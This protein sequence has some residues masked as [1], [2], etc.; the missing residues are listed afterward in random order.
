MFRGTSKLLID[1][2]GRIS[3]PTRYREGL[4]VQSDSKVVVTVDRDRCLLVY[5]L[6]NWEPIEKKLSILPALD[7]EVRH[8][9]RLIL[10]YASEVDIDK[11]G[12]VLIS[13]ELREFAGLK[14]QAILTGQG[15]KFELWDEGSWTE[16]M[17]AW[18]NTSQKKE[19]P[20]EL[21][22]LSL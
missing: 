4:S 19:L 6:I 3:I 1:A 16:R 18:I 22:K 20:E 14:R 10:G 5:P 11:S 2:K 7:N 21:R 12:R 8:Y 13:K 9:Q 15:N 17:D